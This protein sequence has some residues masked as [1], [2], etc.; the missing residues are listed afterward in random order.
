MEC[1]FFS[2]GGETTTVDNLLTRST[3]DLYLIH[4][5]KSAK[6]QKGKSVKV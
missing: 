6:V 3:T 4:R 5:S 1:F 2:G